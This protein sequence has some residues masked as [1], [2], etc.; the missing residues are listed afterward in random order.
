MGPKSRNTQVEILITHFISDKCWVD[1]WLFDGCTNPFRTPGWIHWNDVKYV[2]FV[3]Y[4]AIK[5]ERTSLGG[6]AGQNAGVRHII[7]D[8][9]QN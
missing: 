9:F 8:C 3:S 5:D 2:G 7:R 4:T 1:C 6:T